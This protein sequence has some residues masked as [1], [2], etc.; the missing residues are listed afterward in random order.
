MRRCGEV[1]I[2]G[3]G[4][5]AF[6]GVAAGAARAPRT[7][8]FLDVS[9]QNVQPING[10]TFNRQPRAGD[11]FPIEDNLYRWAGAKRGKLVG[12]V[13]GI[14]TFQVVDGSGGRVL[15]FAQAYIPGGS[16]DV[17]GYGRV[18]FRGPSRFTFPI[19]GGTGAFAGARGYVQVRDL[20]NGNSNNSNVKVHLLP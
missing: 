7:F 8:S 2:L 20:G 15:F 17:Q 1:L 3:L 14:G 4:M 16:I 19:T 11:M 18:S 13:E 5:L 6:S 10:F 12:R 9:S